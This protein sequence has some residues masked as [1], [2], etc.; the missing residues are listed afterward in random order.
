MSSIQ[1]TEVR[2]RK[3]PEITLSSLFVN[4]SVNS[5]NNDCSS[6]LEYDYHDIKYPIP[7][8]ELVGKK[9]NRYVDF[10][11][12]RKGFPSFIKYGV[13]QPSLNPDNEYVIVT[14]A[15]DN[16][17][18]SLVNLLYSTLLANPYSPLVIVD[19]GIY[20]AKL[21]SLLS[22]LTQIQLIRKRI[23]SES[24]I[25]YRKYDFDHFPEW[26]RINEPLSFGGYSWKIITIFD[27]ITEYKGLVFWTDAGS[28]LGNIDK[29]IQNAR[30]NG[31]YSNDAG[32]NIRKW[33]HPGMVQYLEEMKWI[34]V[35]NSTLDK[36]CCSGGYL[37]IDSRNRT[38]MKNVVYP[39]VKCSL[40][41]KCITP[42]GS[43]RKNHR[44]DQSVISIFVQSLGI[45]QA[46]D[47]QYRSSVSF[48]QDAEKR[49]NRIDTDR[50]FLQ[51]LKSKYNI[52][53]TSSTFSSV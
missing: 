34:S 14:G 26:S 46:C 42:I 15:S 27:I 29:D 33:T 43:S 4:A 47:P 23:G 6:L 41:K 53:V 8:N 37:M 24:P 40:T 1:L 16:H 50:R 12:P 25:Y 10:N 17:A 32:H 11:K 9:E 18:L 38:V 19:Y 3:N 5:G 21:K 31:F 13:V 51:T 44:Q 48:H 35:M 20:E 30:M 7:F 36:W 49:N 45:H 28:I 39:T 2:V 52:T 22:N